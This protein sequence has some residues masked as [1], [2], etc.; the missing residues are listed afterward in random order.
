MH[1]ERE[2]VQLL[3]DYLWRGLLGV[4]GDCGNGRAKMFTALNNVE[5]VQ[6]CYV[7]SNAEYVQD[8]RNR[9]CL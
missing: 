1:V 6:L 4:K 2:V 5:Y 9:D 3:L 7:C 8:R